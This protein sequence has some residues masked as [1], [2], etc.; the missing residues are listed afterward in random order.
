M[1]RYTGGLKQDMRP[2]LFAAALL[3]DLSVLALSGIQIHF[4]EAESLEELLSS[5]SCTLMILQLQR[6]ALCPRGLLAITR[7]LASSKTT[8][9]R[10]LLFDCIEVE[11]I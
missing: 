8:T 2:I 7:G 4:G 11:N 10:C 5:S 1:S 3:R 6:N 9:V